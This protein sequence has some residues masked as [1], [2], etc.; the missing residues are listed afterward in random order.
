MRE[1]IETTLQSAFPE[2]E[3]DSSKAK[4]INISGG[5]LRRSVEAA[6]PGEPNHTNEY[7]RTGDEV[8]RG[9]HLLDYF[10]RTREKDQPFLHGELFTNRDETFSGSLLQLVPSANR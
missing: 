4:C 10:K 6:R 9:I 1:I 8:Y 2:A 7:V 5:S 3:V